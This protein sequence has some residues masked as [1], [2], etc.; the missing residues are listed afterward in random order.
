V[1]FTSSGLP[2]LPASEVYEL[3]LI[4]ERG[5]RP[6]GLLP[7]AGGE[8]TTPVLASGLEAGDKVGVTV[9]PAGGTTSPTTTPIVVM[10][11]AA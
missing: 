8:S 10:A 1:V 2:A 7:S 9:E 3:W 5:V 4:G 11:V 6:A